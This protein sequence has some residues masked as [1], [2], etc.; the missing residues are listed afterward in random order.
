MSSSPPDRKLRVVNVYFHTNV[1]GIEAGILDVL[2]RLD[3]SRFEPRLVCIRKLGSRAGLLRE[4]GVPVRLCRCYSRLPFSLSVWR[5][6]RLLR[7]LRPDVVHGHSEIPAQLVTAA[8]RAA[9]VPVVVATFHSVDLFGR[10]GELERERS[11][12]GLRDATIHVSEAV[13]EDYVRRVGAPGDDGVIVYN[14]V[15][16]EFF[17]TAPDAEHLRRLRAS[18]GIDGRRPVLLMVSRLHRDKNHEVV[19]RAFE[20]LR[21]HH[22]QAVLLFAGEGRHRPRIA[23][24]IRE[25]ALEDCVLLLGVRQ[26]IRDL[27]HLADVNILPSDKEGFSTVVLEAMAAGL[28]QVLTP[29]GGN[30]EAVG[31]SGCAT[32]VPVG[33][34][35]ALAGAVQ[36]ILDEP[37]VAESMRRAAL[38]RAT[39]FS[40]DRQ[41]RDTERVYLDA[42]GRSLASTSASSA[43]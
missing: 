1:G 14:G 37:S 21:A 5:L 20:T 36:R 29:V 42:V 27:Y 23:A 7:R 28:P 31:E 43:R 39:R 32:F 12:T 3:R 4:R 15:D 17:S 33:D 26:D 19:V 34:A 25:R 38:A 35:E 11:Q 24:V 40:I 16:V 6:A 13:R 41:V 9:G 22:P 18:L 10:K 8:G 2:P 30:P